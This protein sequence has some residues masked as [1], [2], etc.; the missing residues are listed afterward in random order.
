ML[1]PNV[2]HSK[3]PQITKAFNSFTLVSPVAGVTISSSS[4]RT[5]PVINEYDLKTVQNYMYHIRDNAEQ[6]VRHLLREVV[7]R[8]GTT[9]LEATDYM[10]DGSPVSR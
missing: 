7:K 9:V 1:D 8:L 5:C 4:N 6:S 10:D 2:F 3:S